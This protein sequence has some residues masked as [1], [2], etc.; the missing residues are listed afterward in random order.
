MAVHPRMRQS[1]RRWK[2]E[3]DDCGDKGLLPDTIPA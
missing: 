3:P 1:G 2:I